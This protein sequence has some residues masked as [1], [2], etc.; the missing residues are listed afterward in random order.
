MHKS[1]APKELA[2]VFEAGDPVVLPA[3]DPMVRWNL[4]FTLGLADSVMLQGALA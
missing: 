1:F 3:W 4:V 2:K